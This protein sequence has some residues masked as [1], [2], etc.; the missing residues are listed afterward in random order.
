MSSTDAEFILEIRDNGRGISDEEN[1]IAGSLGLLGM[2]ERAQLVGGE[3]SI[4]GTQGKGTTITVRVPL[5]R[6]AGEV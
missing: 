4:T 6:A 1:D 2:H 3:F 5:N